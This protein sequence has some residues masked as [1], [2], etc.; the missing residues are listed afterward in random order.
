MNT[1]KIHLS[2]EYFHWK[3]DEDWQK[4]SYTTKTIRNIYTEPSRNG[5]EVIRSESAQLEG[6]TQ[7]EGGYTCSEIL[8]G[9]WAVWNTYWDPK[10]QSP[11]QKDE[12]S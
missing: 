6:D 9:E 11:T 1:A 7:E 3:Q 5:N 10:L 12:C 2:V 8:P 4:N